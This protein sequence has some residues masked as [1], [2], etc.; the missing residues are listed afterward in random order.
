MGLWQRRTFIV[1]FYLVQGLA[2]LVGCYKARLWPFLTAP[3]VLGYSFTA[4]GLITSDFLTPNLS[5]ISKELLHISERV[6]GMTLLALGNSVP[7][8]T[9]TYHSMKSD[10]TPLALGELLGAI[11]FLLSVIVGIMPMV[12][13]ID[14][15]NLSAGTEENS[16]NA[17]FYSR[18]R[19]LKDLIMFAIMIALALCFLCDGR[20]MFWECFLMVVVYLCYVLYQVAFE[21]DE[22]GT[23]FSDQAATSIEDDIESQE[24]QPASTPCPRDPAIFLQELELRKAHLRA[25]IKHHLRSSYSSCMKMSLNEILNIW[26]NKDIFEPE[27]SSPRLTK[28]TSHQELRP[29]VAIIQP[30]PVD[31]TPNNHHEERFPSDIPCSRNGQ[32]FLKPPLRASSRSVSA[33]Y[34]LYLDNRIQSTNSSFLGTSLSTECSDSDDDEQILTEP[35]ITK[36]VSLDKPII[37]SVILQCWNE[38]KVDVGFVELFTVLAVSPVV[39]VLRT[40]IPICYDVEKRKKRPLKLEALQVFMAPLAINYMMMESLQIWGLL[41]SMSLTGILWFFNRKAWH[42]LAIR[43]V[44]VVAFLLSLF[45]ISFVVKIVVGVLEECALM[46]N[47]SQAMLGLTIFAWGNSIGDLATTITFTKMGVLDIALGACFGGPLLYFLFG[48]GIDGMLVM[49]FRRNGTR[50]EE[51]SL[52]L[53]SIDFQVNSLLIISCIG[54]LAIFATYMLLIPMNNWRIDK[55]I[56]IVFLTLYGIITTVNVY[57]EA[58]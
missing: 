47:I 4:L 25:K 58:T 51:N 32:D 38:Q 5:I 6:S 28:S 21:G 41:T 11:V 15:S 30:S 9:S 43:C 16:D 50:V 12:R 42:D 14:F 35:L 40:F 33:D 19:F 20:L 2:V 18:R 23:S 10:A 13:T 3:V 26:D 37:Q 7:D 8:I 56:G 49:F 1:G 44:C 31:D 29:K 53:E 22:N 54:L 57:L 39:L 36:V 17:L 45:T 34:L 27:V 46:L 55:K 52:W 48:V 24:F